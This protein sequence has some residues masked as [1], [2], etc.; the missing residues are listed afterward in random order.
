MKHLCEKCEPRWADME[1]LTII[2]M[3]PC[4]KCG[5]Y[6]DRNKDGG[7]RV[8]V[9]RGTYDSPVAAAALY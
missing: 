9:F 7:S 3:A 4:D 6:D 5:A 1:V 2:S 8:H